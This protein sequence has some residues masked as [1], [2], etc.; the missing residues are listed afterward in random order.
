MVPTP[1]TQ[2]RPAAS[3]T[4]TF[5]FSD[6]E[7]SSRL[8]QEV[9]TEAYAALLARHRSILR[10]AFEAHGGEEQGTEG[11]SFF[12]IFPSAA[13]A[14]RA[15]IDAQRGLADA[16]WPDGRAI[17]V[18][19]GLHTGEVTRSVDG[20][21]GIDIN[22]GARIS[23]AGHGGQVLVST[24]TRGLVGE[25]LPDGV[26]WRDLGTYRLRD[27]PEP[28]RLSQLVIDGLPTDFPALR[29]ADARPNNLPSTV[30][31]FVGRERE[32]TEARLLLQT[33]R[34][35]TVTGL[36]GI[37]KT[38]FA[39]ELAHRAGVDFPDGTF[40]VPFE[41]VDDPVLVPGAIAQAVGI[42]EIGARQPVD[43]LKELLGGRR[44]LL[45]LDNFERL[46]AAAPVI[47]DLLR[48]AP[49]LRFVV[50]SRA[51]LHLSGEQEFPLE[52][53]TVPPD[54]ERLNPSELVGRTGTEAR[55]TAGEGLLTYS[56]VRLFVERAMAAR[57]SFS[58]DPTNAATVARICARLDGSPLAIELAAA[59][60]RLLPPDA[61]LVRLERQFELL[62]SS[63]RDVPERQRTLRGAIAWSYD[64]LAE[65]HQHLLERLAC[66]IGGCDLETA[67]RVCGPADELGV[68]VFDGIAEL[69]DQSLVR[70]SEAGD[71]IRFTIPETI[72]QFA[73]ER[74]QARGETDEIR[75]RHAEAFLDLARAAAIELSG[76]DQ[77]RWVERLEREHDN[78]RA[79]LTWATEAPAPQVALGLAFSL[80]RF[81]Q[82]RGHLLE[83][84]RRLEE[85]GAR[86]WA[87]EEP[88]AYARFLEALGGIAYWQGDFAGAVRPY[89][90]ALDIW[91][92][93][94]DR[95]EIA[96]ALYNL[97]FTYNIDANSQSETYVYDLSQ[98]REQL[99]ESL[100]IFREI[101]DVRGIGNVL[102][103][104]GSADMFAG[105]FDKALPVFVEAREAFR[106]VGDKTMEAWALHMAGVLDTQLGNYAGA[107]DAFRHAYGHF[108]DA[109]DI[110]GQSLIVE[111]FASL[112]LAAGEPERGI[113]LW[114]AARRIQQ[115]IGA[116]L[117]QAQ[118]N[119]G[120]KN[121]WRDPLPTDAT[122]ARRAE[123]EAEGRG[124]TL[125]EALAYALDGVVPEGG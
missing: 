95:A 14:V 41:P 110:T 10:T 119:S 71:D 29:T 15:A 106:S 79:A 44:V 67:E 43:V 39:I 100:A 83:A 74:L 8:E 51:I 49:G 64:L 76:A 125:E 84:R 54:I 19:I 61:I 38:R 3:G 104:M 17:R 35:L 28:E 30:T 78:M 53:L 87:P 65:P 109:G 60:I 26:A 90:A 121:A 99:A 118:I 75:R 7:G 103:A 102:W 63:A 9:G 59:R 25:A 114:A 36:G 70:T 1:M 11:D 77:R 32:L 81:W 21:V 52:G 116:G 92:E 18:R 97:A 13:E 62:A 85:I 105:H 57:P 86:A 45:V 23:A 2:D 55:A 98:G 80:W 112:A 123:L 69:A 50:T 16:D 5:L 89:Q 72:R 56:A 48:A 113:R 108:A 34:L 94:G 24:A 31:S 107:E 124:W 42:V 33:A 66:F 120:G 68:D 88:V 101:G 6:I 96:N 73:Y 37:G 115:T 122:P 46:T 27:F 12:V 91:R 22:R 111:D 20:Y 93:L 58:L 47:G 82:K 4:L 40:F 117:V